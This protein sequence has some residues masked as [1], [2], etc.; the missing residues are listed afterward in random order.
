M[1][2]TIT[3]PKLG[4]DMQEGTLVR[5]VRNEGET[6]NKGDVLAEI[7]TD[8]ATVEVES[9]ASGVVRRLLVD[10]GSVVP[11]GAAIAIVGSKDEPIS[12]KAAG[13]S[14]TAKPSAL[15]AREAGAVQ[16]PKPTAQQAQA[17]SQVLA[18]S[19]AGGPVKASPLAKRI[20]RDSGIDLSRVS[21][22]G[23]G[24]RVTRKDV[25]SAAA[26]SGAAMP[27]ATPVFPAPPSAVVVRRED[28]VVTPTKLRQII[29]RRMAE[30]K[31][32]VPHFYVTHEYQMDA[33]MD[34][35]KQVNAYLPDEGKIS[36]NDFIVRAV[37]LTLREFP[38]LN[39]AL[40]G[41]KVLRHGAVNVGVAVAVE[42][43]L[44]TVVCRDAD[45]KPL[46][47][48]SMELKTMA[49]RARDGKV[50]T[51]DIENSTFSV[52]NL[53][54]FDVENFA[55]II[56]PPEA[57]ILAVGSARQVPVVT[58]SGEI[59]PGWRMKATIAVDHRVSDGAEGAQFMQ[60]LAKYLEE[61]VRLL[62]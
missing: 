5:W 33:L 58:S 40:Q 15:P 41:D 27:S 17:P 37:A 26:Q 30:S 62:V 25:E 3:M 29:A 48:I 38:N 54:M 28:E 21:G 49:G 44:L 1:A 10:Q 24:G 13:A 47:Q 8:K 56:N 42:G 53:G 31:S 36:V 60:A 57:G 43:G 39:S 11:I 61:P 22:T 51:D 16:Q 45:Q 2:E 6:I 32:T 12:D 50:K 23:P 46:R 7:E 55:A 34:L 20:A 35:R 18:A 14:K 59:Q 19:A 9:S 52:S 4:F